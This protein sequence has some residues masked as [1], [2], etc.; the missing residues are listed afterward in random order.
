MF[1]AIKT[2]RCLI[3][4]ALLL[5][6]ALV[7]AANAQLTVHGTVTDGETSQPLPGVTVSVRGTTLGTTTAEDGTYSLQVPV[8][9]VTL[10]FSFVGYRTQEFNVS[11]SGEKIDVVLQSNVLG[12]DEFVVVGSRRQPRLL[13]DSA[14]P[15]DVLGPSDLQSMSSTDMDDVIRTQIPSYNLQSLNGDEAAIVRPATLRGLPTDNVIVLVNGKRR[16]RSGSIA[17]SAGSLNEGAQGP[18]L[19]MIPTIAL[20]QIEI[21]RDGATAQYGADAVAGVFNLQLREDAQGV[22]ARLRTGQY[23]KGDGRYVHAAANTGFSLPRNGFANLS[24]EYRDVQPTVRSAQRDDATTLAS[25]GYP[26]AD[27]A[28]LWGGAEVSHGVVGFLNSGFDVTPGIRG[29]VFG[30]GGRR[31][32]EYGFYF[33][34]PGTGTARSSVFRFGSERAVVDLNPDGGVDCRGDKALPD[35]DATNAEVQGFIDKFR[36]ECFLFNEIFPGGFTP[37]FGGDLSDI[38]LTA[39]LRSGSIDG[40]NWDISVSGARSLLNFFIYRT[41]N[42]SYGPDT[43]TSF[44]PRSYFQQEAE[45]SAAFSIPL[46]V[47]RLASP[48]HLAWGATWRTEIF[49]S[50]PGDPRSWK[51]GPYADQGF[52]VGSNGYQGLNPD[53]AGRWTRP[54]FAIYVDAEADLTR[55]LLADIAVRYENFTTEFGST[56]NGKL[57]VLYRATDR[58]SLRAATSTGFR[59]PTPGQANLN[60][61]RTTGFSKEHGLI[62]VGVLPPVHPISEALGGKPLTPELAN[63]VSSGVIAEISEEFTLT[64][65]YFQINVRDRLSLT[66]N[67][68]I[69]DEIVQIIDSKDILGGVTN[70]REVRFYSN[71]FSTQ[72]KGL[73]VLLAWQREWGPTRAISGSIAWNWTATSLTH[74]TPPSEITSFL[75]QT[76]RDPL[77]LGLLTKR[78]QVEMEEINPKHRLVATHRQLF[79]R[80]SALFRVSWFDS[81]Q[82]CRF[83]SSTCSEDGISLLDYFPSVWLTDVEIGYALRDSWEVTLGVNNLFDVTRSAH[84]EETHRQGNLSPRSTPFDQNG[85]SVYIRL[86]TDL[87]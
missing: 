7:P 53:F 30:G 4:L 52:S 13:K 37:R 1:I 57:A 24:L 20:R 14:V 42:A 10:V 82:A 46:A 59:A 77:T 34:S 61:F 8:G 39:G 45:V 49:E 6:A 25:R 11:A 64:A 33:R 31:T 78:R 16:H 40:L 85:T 80:W 74:F 36:G 67:I 81:W 23:L 32:Q 63:S 41:V 79:N 56:L 5:F 75:G 12:L 60:V 70:I 19:N 72:T 54:N 9:D 48:I 50:R 66:G 71:D 87:Y 68:P 44:K 22:R 76:L 51:A 26:V 29:Y 84:V 43:P 2:F 3:F 58:I 65:D 35:L 62:E 21:L 38:S 27:P 47:H 69:T 15:V 28:Q 18:D 86:T 17:L 55:R 83:A 73:D